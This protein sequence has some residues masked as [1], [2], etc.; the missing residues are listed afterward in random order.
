LIWRQ[1]LHLL[2]K[3]QLAP[4]YT[5]FPPVVPGCFLLCLSRPPPPKPARPTTTVAI[6]QLLP[7]LVEAWKGHNPESI[8]LDLAKPWWRTFFKY[9]RQPFEGLSL[10][11]RESD[12]YRAKFK[13]WPAPVENTVV[14]LEVTGPFDPLFPSSPTRLN[15]CYPPHLSG[16]IERIGI[17]SGR[18]RFFRLDAS[19]RSP[20]QPKRIEFFFLHEDERSFPEVIVRQFYILRELLTPPLKKP[21]SFLRLCL[22]LSTFTLRLLLLPTPA[23]FLPPR[24]CRFFS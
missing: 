7:L 14:K 24:F 6:G 21:P 16:S 12:R 18:M 5:D 23:L 8:S 1:W 15:G 2:E 22:G 11:I 13:P 20:T 10:F 17:A 19:A 3:V 9:V 4:W